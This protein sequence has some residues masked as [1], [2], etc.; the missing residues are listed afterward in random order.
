[1]SGEQIRECDVLLAVTDHA[2]C[3]LD[4]VF[5]KRARQL[6]NLVHR[7]IEIVGDPVKHRVGLQTKYLLQVCG[8]EVSECFAANL[9]CYAQSMLRA[10]DP[11]PLN[12]LAERNTGSRV[13]LTL[14]RAR[15]KIS[16]EEIQEEVCV[17]PCCSASRRPTLLPFHFCLQTALCL[18]ELVLDNLTSF[19]VGSSPV[20]V[21]CAGN[22]CQ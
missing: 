2:D 1:M 11:L 18:I 21:V 9:E 15:R 19:A 7:I 10:C 14:P 5:V 6:D 16:S 13:A 3:L 22:K 12:K 4:H 20:L 17:A 8:D